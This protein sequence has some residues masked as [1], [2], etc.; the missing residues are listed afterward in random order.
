METFNRYLVTNSTNS[1]SLN[2]T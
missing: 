1:S 2:I